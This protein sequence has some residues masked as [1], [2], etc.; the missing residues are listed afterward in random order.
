MPNG[1]R[2]HSQGMAGPT[3]EQPEDCPDQ[4][5]SKRTKLSR[6][7]STYWD[8]LSKIWLTKDA[9]EELNRRNGTSNITPRVGR[10]RYRP[11]IRQLQTTLKQH[12]QTL[13]PDP[14]SG[15]TPRSLWEIRKLSM[16]GGPDLSDLRNYPEPHIL[17]PRDNMVSIRSSGRRKRLAAS[18]PDEESTS[19][20]KTAKTSS[21]SPY[22]RNFEQKLIDYGV[23]PSE[24]MY[25]KGETFAEPNNWEELNDRLERRRASLSPSR[26]TSE[27]FRAFKLAD[28]VAS[29]E[30]PISRFAIPIMDGHV[31]DIRCIGMDYPFG[32]L[33][34][35]TDGSLA[36]AKPDY[37]YGSLPDQL[38]PQVRDSLSRYII[39]STQTSLPMVPNFFLET[40]GPDGLPTVAKRQACYH[41]AL[42][43]R[44]MHRLQSYKRDEVY[45]NN[46]YTI[47]STYQDGQLKLYTTHLTA[48]SGNSNRPEYIMTPLRSF[49]MTDRLSTLRSGIAAY[50]NARDWA[51]EQRDMFIQS[52][53]ERH[54]QAQSEENLS[55]EESPEPIAAAPGEPDTSPTPEEVEPRDAAWSFARPDGGAA[56]RASSPKDKSR[57][58]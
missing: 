44:G 40:K 9:L 19:K 55:H 6:P 29:K 32:N 20:N 47:T 42:G 18:P 54:L 3:R 13:A 5:P 16:H 36:T 38:N 17:C 53:N 26:F 22:N 31:E 57:Q 30:R 10:T 23:Y 48:P 11:P 45:D 14:S 50:R 2:I 27:E 24:Y 7:S 8:T 15:C 52:A 51:E 41:G 12:S 43:A 46:T 33:A 34:P 25:P 37:F 49:S 56:P 4:P 28:L 35:L 39:P 1:A 21:T 58:N